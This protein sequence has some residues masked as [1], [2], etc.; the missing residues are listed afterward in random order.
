MPLLPIEIAMWKNDILRVE[1]A[2]QGGF[3]PNIIFSSVGFTPLQFAVGKQIGIM[4]ML[5]DHG[6]DVSTRDAMG[7]TALHY[8]AKRGYVDH[9]R[10]LLTYKADPNVRDG[11]GNT[12][13]HT[14]A[15][16]GHSNC[17]RA[18][19]DKGGAEETLADPNIRDVKGNTPLHIAA[20]YGHNNC[21]SALFDKGAD[22]TLCNHG[23]RA[24][25]MCAWE[26]RF[27]DTA[28]L[29]IEK[30]EMKEHK[31]LFGKNISECELAVMMATHHRLV[32]NSYLRRLDVEV[33]DL[34]RKDYITKK[35]AGS[36][37]AELPSGQP[38]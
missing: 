18:L 26:A 11:E 37:V 16:Y 3:D 21:V 31:R 25:V 4:Q 17:V 7:C 15:A 14:A 32:T 23:G 20:T 35:R 1:I 38:M 33:I 19:L 29:I 12:P 22:E 5:L 2:L 10:L 24:P 6:A 8:A 13:L 30:T 36:H 9:L 27:S 28:Y 34:I